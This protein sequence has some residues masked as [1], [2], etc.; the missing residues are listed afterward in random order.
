MKQTPLIV[1]VGAI[2]FGV[3]VFWTIQSDN[4]FD[5]Q[6]TPTPSVSSSPSDTPTPTATPKR[7]ILSPKPT[8]GL[9]AK[10]VQNHQQLV[11]LLDPFNR[12]LALD[13]D[14]T[15]LVP[16]QVAYPNDLE[17]MIDN[18]NSAIARVL[19]IG[20]KQYS[21]DAHSWILVTLHS[22]ALPAK[23]PIFCGAMELGQIDLLAK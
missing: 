1:I 17:I 2:L 4:P 5:A 23:L 9:I 22:D 8:P 18:Y 19:R 11:E 12:R 20:D 10:D 3:I 13:A 14:C 15:A 7:V 21:L 6:M 16:S